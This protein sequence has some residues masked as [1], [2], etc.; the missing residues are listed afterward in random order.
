MPMALEVLR[1]LGLSG[2]EVRVYS[3]LLDSGPSPVHRIHEKTGIERRNIYD[4]LNKLIERG[5][6]TYVAENKKRFFHLAPPSRILGYI[7]EKKHGLDEIKKEVENEI[8]SILKKFNAG[9]PEINAEIFR[10]REGVKTVWEDML[11]CKEN[12]WIGSGRYIPKILPHFFAG[13]NRRRI[14][15]RVKWFNLMRAELRGEIKKPFRL[16]YLKFLP[17]EFSGNPTAVSIYGNKVANFLFEEKA[18]FAIVIEN[19]EI[20]ENYR[21]YH[22]YLWDN[23]AK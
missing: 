13:W 4:I 21:R 11:N 14:Q 18:L 16:E 2:G 10:G 3:A 23:V 17:K 9:K 1:K 15:S 5:L 8:P 6:A 12:Y 22:K 20:A 7:R 19:K